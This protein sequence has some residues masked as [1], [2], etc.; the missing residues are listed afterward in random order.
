MFIREFLFSDAESLAEW[1]TDYARR[2]IGAAIY[3]RLE[4]RARERGGAAIHTEASRISRPFFA[5]HGYEL[6]E[7]EHVVRFGVEFERC[8]RPAGDL[9]DSFRRS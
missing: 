9:V 4:A 8:K 1:A 2:G 5:K 6:I 3:A 7:V